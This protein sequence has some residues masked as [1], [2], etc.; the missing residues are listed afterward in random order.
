MLCV[1]R[2]AVSIS[3]TGHSEYRSQLPNGETVPGTR[4]LGHVHINGG[5]ALN[6]FGKAFKAAGLRWT[7][8]L[9]QADSDGD[10][11]SNGLELGDPC[12]QWTADG[13]LPP[14]RSWR[15]SHPGCNPG[16]AMGT[17]CGRGMGLCDVVCASGMSMP[18]CSSS[19]VLAAQA[20][21]RANLLGRMRLAEGLTSTATFDRFY[22]HAHRDR[23][24]SSAPLSP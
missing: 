11:E 21:A 6:V 17:S 20:Q 8:A 23:T 9:C 13:A 2:L 5:G 7:Q 24:R 1:L 16:G 10:G 22:W 15:I 4:A 12:C 14:H 18:N 3:C 19:S